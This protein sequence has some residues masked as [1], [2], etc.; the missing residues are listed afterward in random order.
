MDKFEIFNNTNLGQLTAIFGDNGNIW[1]LTKDVA[2]ILCMKA[3]HALRLVDPED[4]T[5]FFINIG[6]GRRKYQCVNEYGIYEMIFA[7]KKQEAKTFRKWVTHEVLPSIRKNGGYII[8]QEE[9][10]GEEKEKLEEQIRQLAKQVNAYREDGNLWM[11]M[12]FDIQTD[13]VNAVEK[14]YGK[15]K[16]DIDAPENSSEKEY[17]VTP[18]GWILPKSLMDRD[19]D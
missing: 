12:Y 14:I 15:K 19:E 10:K 7:S 11:K 4:R 18:E 17:V 8:G 16:A 6:T 3:E 13:Y 2:K 1:F 5:E 9:L